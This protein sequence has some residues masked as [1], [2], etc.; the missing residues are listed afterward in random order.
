LSKLLTKKGDGSIF[1]AKNRTVPLSV[2]GKIGARSTFLL[3][4]EVGA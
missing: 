4:L 1:L 2:A 3:P